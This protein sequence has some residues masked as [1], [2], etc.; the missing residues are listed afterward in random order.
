MRFYIHIVV[1]SDRN[2]TANITIRTAKLEEG[3]YKILSMS[4]QSSND[5]VVCE[6]PNDFEY[7][8]LKLVILNK[9]QP[10]TPYL[11]SGFVGAFAPFPALYCHQ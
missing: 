8:D 3:V 11:K 10:V 9:T 6:S 5:R 1:G 4:G 7:S 2:F